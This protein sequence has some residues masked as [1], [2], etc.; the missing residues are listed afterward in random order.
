MQ[1]EDEAFPCVR[2]LLVALCSVSVTL[3]L[4]LRQ[5]WTPFEL[6]FH[7]QRVRR[8]FGTVH[9]QRHR[10]HHLGGRKAIKATKSKYTPLSVP[11]PGKIFRWD[12]RSPSPPSSS[13]SSSS[14]T[15]KEPL[16]VVSWNLE[17]GYQLDD[18]MEQLASL[19]PDVVLLQEVDLF[20]NGRDLSRNV[21]TAIAARLR[22]N[23]VWA[24]HHRYFLS[25]A[26]SSSS[27][28]E[29]KVKENEGRE[30]GEREEGRGGGC[31][32]NAILTRW[33]VEEESVR[34]LR[35]EHL[36]GY[37]RSA[38]CARILLPHSSSSSCA[39]ASSSSL[40]CCSVH[41][42]VCCGLSRRL[43]QF[44]QVL[45]WLQEDAANKPQQ[46]EGEA[47]EGVIIGGDLNTLAHG[48]LRLSPFHCGDEHRWQSVGWTEAQWWHHHIFSSSSSPSSSFLS[49]S[50]LNF[51]HQLGLRD[52]FCKDV[53]KE[54]DKRRTKKRWLFLKK[55]HENED[56]EEV[57]MENFWISAKMDW[58]LLSRSLNV[59]DKRVG[60]GCNASDHFWLSVDASVS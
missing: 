21:C 13:S 7:R 14:F 29:R 27:L 42:E 41:L 16:R 43:Q 55:Q 8:Y 52:P 51:I 32:G 2:F 22:M 1:T 60:R 30:E 39:S 33:D 20:D 36:P 18:I 23:A 12:F 38:L 17:F 6:W 50:T 15:D 56:E 31:W 24:G 37:D 35:L 4:A 5:W 47:K 34:F 3:L 53:S 45:S 10:R 57:S 28:R 54:N 19:R 25:S 48:L 40:L 26:S 59:L 9:E 58:L 44:E 11:P 46:R 49:S